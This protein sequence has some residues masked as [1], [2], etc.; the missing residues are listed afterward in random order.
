MI[1][2]WSIIVLW[3]RELVW[4][5][6]LWALRAAQNLSLKWVDSFRTYHFRK[7]TERRQ[8]FHPCL[9]LKK[10][11][12]KIHPL[13][14][15]FS[16]LRLKEKVSLRIGSWRA[17]GNRTNFL[18]LGQEKFIFFKVLDFFFVAIEKMKRKCFKG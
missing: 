18:D 8:W 2:N 9:I 13:I 1:H 6:I 7:T 16:S 4:G 15:Y 5:L 11:I 12:I 14:S 3:L 10:K 17:Q